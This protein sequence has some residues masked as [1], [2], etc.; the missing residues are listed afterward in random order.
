MKSMWEAQPVLSSR[1]TN[2]SLAPFAATPG[3]VFF[4]F[5]LWLVDCFLGMV[6]NSEAGF[7]AFFF[8]IINL[9]VSPV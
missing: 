3:L 4:Y 5:L 2:F 7:V 6:V 8:G 1:D 9:V